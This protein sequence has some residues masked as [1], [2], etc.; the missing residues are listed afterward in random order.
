[1][2]ARIWIAILSLVFWS[3]TA[4][5]QGFAGLGTDAEGYTYPDPEALLEFPDDHG[6]HPEFR[7]EWW[8]VT[9][10]LTG[11]D[12]RD[13]GIQW[14]L[15]RTALAPRE[16]EGWDSPQLWIGHAA[17]TTPELHFVAERLARGGIGQAGVTATPFRAWIDNWEMSGPTLSE[18]SLVAEDLDFGY[19][20]TLAADRPFVL[21]G[22]NG[23]SVK[24]LEG[25]ASHYYSQPFYEV[26]GTLHLPQGDVA[27]T[28]NAWFDREW[29]SQPLTETQ[30]GWDWFS[31]AFDD[32]ARLMGY[33][34]RDTAA[35]V[36]TAATWVTPEGVPTPYPDAAF[37]ADPL[38]EHS[39]AGRSL[40][41]RWRVRLPD[42]GVDVTVAPLNPDTWM[43]TSFPYWEGPIRFEGTH[44][45]RGYLEMTGY[46]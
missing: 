12:E 45:G 41:V 46:E 10:T 35:E 32:G 6:P 36:F 26:S 44:S 4:L 30:S 21:Q 31:L 15:F 1:M 38:S 22:E 34:L 25:Q 29:S 43:S 24:S 8:Y 39:V 42:R 11:S 28:G 37:T 23:Y 33:R 17:L 14:T 40:P 20:L 27:V 9:A 7:I 19:Q 2:S 13:Y 18:V 3:G 16:T 5:A